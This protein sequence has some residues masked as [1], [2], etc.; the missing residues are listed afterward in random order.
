MLSRLG[1]TAGV[2]EYFDERAAP[3]AAR[4]PRSRRSYRSE[5][6]E[7]RRYKGK[8]SEVFSRVLLNLALFARRLPRPARPAAAG[9][10][11]ARRAAGTTLFLALAA[12]HDAFG[13]E[14]GKQNVE[15][16][17]AFVR[18][19]C[20]ESRIPHSEIHEKA[21]RRYRFEL[22]PR[23]DQRLLVLAEGDARAA[24]A[25]LADVP[26]GARFHAIAADLPYGIQ[27]TGTARRRSSPRPRPPGNACSCPAERPRSPGTRPASRATRLAAAVTATLE[28]RPSATTARTAISSTAS[29]A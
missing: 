7:A 13:I 27:H 15:T 12:G 2:F 24:D 25:V 16:T 4:R 11:P 23:D 22:G 19:F 5:L 29:T 21:K 10:R 1:A 14:L 6:A 9:P 28:P 17:A 20:R 18:E 8:T 26:G 3:A